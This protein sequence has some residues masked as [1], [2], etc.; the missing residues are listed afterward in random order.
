MAINLGK[1]KTPD[2]LKP[3]FGKLLFKRE[4][5][6]RGMEFRVEEKA[7]AEMR[8]KGLTAVG[9]KMLEP[10][11]W[12]STLPEVLKF[13]ELKE[14]ERKS[15]AEAFKK[16]Y[17]E[18]YKEIKA[19]SP[20]RMVM[21]QTESLIKRG[22]LTAEEAELFPQ[23][24]LRPVIS[25]VGWVSAKQATE[26]IAK[27]AK[28][29]RK[30]LI[31]ITRGVMK[32]TSKIQI[33]KSITSTPSGKTKLAQIAKNTKIP[34]KTKIGNYIKDLF[35]Q[36]TKPTEP[37]KE[38]LLKGK[39]Q[40]KI[41]PAKALTLKGEIPATTQQ[42]TQAH[43]LAK[44]K[45]MISTLGKVKPQYRALAKGITGKTSMKEMTQEEARSFITSLKQIQPRFIQGE[46]KPPII[47]T[48]QK[49]TTPEF[50]VREF[51]KPTFAKYFTPSD[52]Y[53]RTLGTYDLIEPSI[54]AKTKLLLERQKIFNW[55]DNK[56]KEV[57]KLEKVSLA[58]KIKAGVRA[59]PTVAHEKWFDLLDK[60]KTARDAGLTGKSA[61]IFDEL[62]GLT[63]TVLQRTN[64]VR[65]QVGLEPIQSLKSYI[66]HIEDIVSKKAVQ[67][68]YPFP[69]EVKYW[70]SY[71]QPKHIFNPTALHRFLEDKPG[72]L[73]NPFKALKTM[74]AMDLKQIY[75]EKPNLLFREQL[76][77]LKGQIPADTK[78]WTELY[79]NEVIKGFPTSL[80][81]MTNNTLNT[82]GIT[83]LIDKALTP[84]GRTVGLNPAKE[85]SGALSRLI[86]DA[87][88]W[89]RLKLVVRN[90]TQ[91]LLTL[92][93]YDT[94]SFTKALFPA[95][96]D[97]QA[98]IK[99]NDF[100]KISNREFMERLPEGAL[101]QLE[102]IGFKPY[103]HSHISNIGFAMKT[104]YYG[105]MDLVKNPK[106]TKLGWKTEDVIKEMEFGANTTQY[107]YN[108]MGMPE[109]YR[110][111]IGRTFG[112]L[113]TWW[114]NYTM[115]Y[116]REML[117]RGFTG[118]TGWG[119]EIPVKWRLGALRHIIGSLLFVEGVRRA[120]GWNYKRVALFGVLPT[121][122][123]PPAQIVTGLYNYMFATSD[124][125]KTRAKN[126]ILQSWKAFVPG[127][128]AWK[129]FWKAW[130]EGNM[131]ELLFYTEKKK[132]SPFEVDWDKVF[133]KPKSK[134]VDW[135][136]IF[137]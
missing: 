21:G 82:L 51:H 137:K 37:T 121:Y 52:R 4:P 95:D 74:T 75:L 78:K 70:L 91:K 118:K 25:G 123:S 128:M 61:E 83:K 97:L 124:W 49:L 50:F 19:L 38:F 73:K 66:T 55:I 115:K 88:I 79:V 46:K 27:A 44:E 24:E 93:L 14:R 113:Q 134:E 107:W 86:H 5:E 114:M 30:D 136:K 81:E 28:L 1:I 85:I 48:T 110:S 87:V 77:A 23:T 34:L 133:E 122:L 59:K 135:D 11:I 2:F 57:F 116:W 13:R 104:A 40:A 99:N 127:S 130:E 102:R 71:I 26:L 131:E 33:Y 7:L 41:T 132:P 39:P 42:I 125:Q 129:D 35:P 119:K 105:A 15:E 63:E 68:K 54:K 101:G 20:S 47:P 67:E 10:T 112:V 64:E 80:D 69:E 103:G 126:Q 84:F 92:G 111:G 12:T 36:I 60:N 56:E 90:H 18:R 43:I 108:T 106:Y 65:L 31:D 53:A 3:V 29:T 22:L 8:I 96:K 117:A 94:K 32:D 98:L 45:A 9:G 89:G 72:L 16:Q 120:L 109:I 6:S 62:R 17:P 100:W 76:T 58:A